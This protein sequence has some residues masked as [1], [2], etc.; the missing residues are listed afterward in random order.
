MEVTSIAWTG[1]PARDA[2]KMLRFYRD[3]MG[4]RV[5]RAYPSE[6]Q[7]QLIEFGIGNDHWFSLLTEEL[8]GTDAGTGS[9]I[10]FEVDDI[11]EALERVKEHAI[12]ADEK[13]AD[14]PNCRIAR[15]Q[16]PEG[17]RVTLH[18]FKR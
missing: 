9:G 16:D 8:A 4:L 10:T 17:N 13:A 2:L 5:D 1:Y 6:E 11:D 14:Y 3:V 12:T 7:P 15:F 18:Q